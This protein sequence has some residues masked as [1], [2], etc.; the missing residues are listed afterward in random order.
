[1]IFSLS[2]LPTLMMSEL[3]ELIRPYRLVILPVFF[4]VFFLL[5]FLGVALGSRWY[6]RETFMAY[7][8]VLLLVF[9]FIAPVTLLPFISWSHFAEPRPQ[10]VHHDEIRIVDANGNELKI[11]KHGTLNS[12]GISIS[13]LTEAM[14]QEYDEEK[15]E[16]V[17]RYL[18][19]KSRERRQDVMTR[20]AIDYLRFPPHSL[21]S[22]W[23]PSVLSGTDRFIGIR[24]YRMTF[25]TSSN[26]TE[27]RSYEET[28]LLEVYP[29]ETTAPT[30]PSQNE[31][32]TRSMNRT[33]P[34]IPNGE[35]G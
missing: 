18:I 8:F 5:A 24:I 20:S 1:M 6:A 13:R 34:R 14:L 2:P 12:D 21:T 17:T 7:F 28:L 26:G 33:A 9:N 4:T 10:T 15:N 16:Q 35:V 30:L 23:T 19:S 22:T 27:I 31:S 32:P 25:V 11:D 29:D 3:I